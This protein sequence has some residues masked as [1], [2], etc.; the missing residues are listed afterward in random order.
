MLNE[1]GE[2]QHTFLVPDHKGNDL[3]FTI[4]Y[5]VAMGLPCMTFITLKHIPSTA[6]LV[7]QK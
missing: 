5:D 4:K 1:S 3:L 6:T 2:S 7:A